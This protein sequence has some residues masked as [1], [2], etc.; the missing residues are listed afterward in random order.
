MK[1]LEVLVVDD[2]QDFAESLAM[3]IEGRGH[4]VELAHDGRQAI[5]KFRNQDFDIAFMDV[6]LPG[7]NGVESF[8][9]VRK[10]KPHAKVV[11]MTGY[12][13]EQLL[14]QAV[15]NGAWG[16][17]HKPLDVERTLG[18]LEKVKPAG[19]LIADDDA[20]FVESV[21]EVLIS[22]GWRVLVAKNGEEA[23]DQIRSDGVDILILDL[24]MPILNGLETYLE[25]KHSG[26]AVPTIVVTAYADE[27]AERISRLLSMSVNGIMR[28]PFDP[29]DLIE[30]VERL[31]G[32]ATG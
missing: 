32:S 31:A 17:L 27:E 10:F 20:D 29:R 12:S 2:D 30:A 25:L 21:R 9:E 23:V 14:D 16:V 7:M 15:E 6:K 5:E 1:Q 4:K 22:Q 19:I 18:M 24:R 13:V 11:M 8:L 26:L 28:K 3:V